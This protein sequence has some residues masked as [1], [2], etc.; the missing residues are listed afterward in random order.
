MRLY[1]LLVLTAFVLHVIWERSHIV[2]YT[3]YEA[4]EGVLPVFVFATIG[5]VVYTFGAVGLVAL[6]KG[7]LTWFFKV[8]PREIIGLALIGLWIA[9][10]VEYK[11]MALGR[12]EYTDAMPLIWGLPVSPLIQM[13]LLLPLSVFLAAVV[14]RRIR[15]TLGA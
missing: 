1:A 5:D 7:S 9:L 14:E 4:M 10:F 11:A 15:G 3:G 2:L 6:F 12:W 13:T 8:E